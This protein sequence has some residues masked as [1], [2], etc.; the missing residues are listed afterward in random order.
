[1]NHVDGVDFVGHQHGMHSAQLSGPWICIPLLYPASK[2]T[3]P[4][5]LLFAEIIIDK[6][7]ENN[8][9]PWAPKRCY[10]CFK[11][12]YFKIDRYFLGW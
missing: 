2:K 10:R 8:C 4:L 1:M 3:L 7:I 11:K 12:T 6:P 9:P 5:I